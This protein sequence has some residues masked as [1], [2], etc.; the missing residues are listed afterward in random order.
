MM[1][2]RGQ[3]R[4]GPPP[5][6]HA[7]VARAV[8]TLLRRPGLNAA[9]VRGV[10]A[11]YDGLRGGGLRV[12]VVADTVWADVWAPGPERR[13]ATLHSRS[14]PEEAVLELEFSEGALRVLRG[15]EWWPPETVDYL[16]AAT[17][18]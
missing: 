18:E 16:F 2:M 13:R 15:A 12:I 8:G 4:C 14:R 9:D 3:P 5:A 6:E 10:R 11:F 7:R 17:Y 1:A